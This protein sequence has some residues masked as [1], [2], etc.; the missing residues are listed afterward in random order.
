MGEVIR[1]ADVMPK[2]LNRRYKNQAF[3]VQFDMQTRTWKWSV[4]Y[5]TTSVYEGEPKKDMTSAIK[6]AERH[7]DKTMGMRGE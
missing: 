2:T 7:I 1:M 3:T 4:T 6:A 5:V